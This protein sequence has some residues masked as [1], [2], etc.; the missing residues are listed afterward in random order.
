MN[1][2]LE[3]GFLDMD[4]IISDINVP[5][6]FIVGARG[7]GK[8]YGAIQYVAKHDFRA[9][10]MRRTQTQA[11]L[12]LQPEMSA[13]NTPLND[14]G[15]T[16]DTVKLGKNSAAIYTRKLDSDERSD[17]PLSIIMSLATNSNARGFDARGID[18]I[19]YDE[20]IAQP[21]ERPI[22]NE[23]EAF[24]NCYETINRNR[25]LSGKP[26]VK[27]IFMANSFNLANPI[28]TYLKL[29][30]K[31]VKMAEKH[32]EIYIERE[33]GLA[34]IMPSNSPISVAKQDTALYKLVGF[35]NDFARMAI[36]NI[37]EDDIGNQIASRNLREY[38][39]LVVVGETAIYRHK[40]RK[41]YYVT[42]HIT[43]TPK[44]RYESGKAEKAR[45]C[46]NYRFLTIANLEC[47]VFF[48]TYFHQILFDNLWKT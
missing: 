8:T 37:S 13:F 28:F 47:R 23:A 42:S 11:D 1:L 24:F 17:T 33:R 27:C 3:N 29:V 18:I 31:A 46:R 4:K 40:S 15:Y 48:E 6:I 7:I 34:I 39:P 9:V 38:V 44:D 35:D 14:L 41:E 25:E 2:Y 20:F 21:E 12:Q 16:F 5:F 19:L 36:S 10:F 43:G 30:N 45:F 32:R 22:K 26:P